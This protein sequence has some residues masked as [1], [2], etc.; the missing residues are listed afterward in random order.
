MSVDYQV[1]IIPK[2]RS[3]R[4]SADQVANLANA[5]RDG[6][7]VPGPEAPGQHSMILELL[8]GGSELAKTPALVH[9]FDPKPFT[10]SWV[11]SFSRNEL[12]LDWGVNE[13]VAAGV[14]YP[15]V[16]DPYPD[17]G[18]PYFYVYVILG[19]DYFYYVGE[20]VMPFDEEATKCPCGEQLAYR[21]G[22]A[23]GV[24]AQR[25]HRQC[26]K[27]QLT[28]DPSGIACDVLDGWTGQ[29]SPLLGGLTFRSRL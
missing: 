19:D 5:L 12:V 3:F 24:P 17:S 27:C 15:F 28:F 25:I 21:T 26:P 8:P 7:W 16:F 14:Q 29:P 13:M 2:E 23:A 11:D 4:P 20:N 1:W 9:K 22:Y 6:A 10:G 18:P